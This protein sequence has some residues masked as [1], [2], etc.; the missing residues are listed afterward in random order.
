MRRAD[1][2]LVQTASAN[3]AAGFAPAAWLCAGANLYRMAELARI[4]NQPRDAVI[5]CQRIIRDYA[6]SGR[7]Y[8]AIE[9]LK[10]IRREHPGLDVAIPKLELFDIVVD[11]EED[12]A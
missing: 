9:I 6:R 2:L 5:Y 4:E 12:E 10:D 7:G 8:E 11:D 1:E 3:P